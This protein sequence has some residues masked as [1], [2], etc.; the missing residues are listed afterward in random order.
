MTFGP[1]AGEKRLC[2]PIRFQSGGG[3]RAVWIAVYVGC[4]RGN[5]PIARHLCRAG[6]IARELA[7]ADPT[8]ESLGI[9]RRTPCHALRGVPPEWRI[10]GRGSV[11]VTMSRWRAIAHGHLANCC[12]VRFQAHK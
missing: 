4:K 6:A 12:P 11:P 5:V 10:S 3:I 8:D 1:R 9:A 2:G 7:W